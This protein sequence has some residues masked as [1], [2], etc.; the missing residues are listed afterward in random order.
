MA[1]EEFKFLEKAIELEKREELSSVYKVRSYSEKLKLMES[2]EIPQKPI[3]DVLNHLFTEN[4]EISTKTKN[5][6]S[7]IIYSPNDRII[8]LN[9]PLGQDIIWKRNKLIYSYGW[10]F[11]VSKPKSKP[12]KQK[13]EKRKNEPKKEEI[14]IS[15]EILHLGDLSIP[16]KEKENM[17]SLYH[18]RE[19]I[20]YLKIIKSDK[21]PQKPIKEVLHDFLLQNQDIPMKEKKSI[22]KI[23]Y[24]QKERV[25]VVKSL[26]GDKMYE[27]LKRMVKKYGWYFYITGVPVGESDISKAIDKIERKFDIEYFKDLSLSDGNKDGKLR[28]TIYPIVLKPNHNCH[29]LGLG[30]LNI[31][32]DC[33]ISEPEIIQNEAVNEQLESSE[34][35]D[36][37]EIEKDVI[38]EEVAEQEKILTKPDDFKHIDDYLQNFPQLISEAEKE[39]SDI[40]EIE[41]LPPY[42]PKIDAVF[43]SHSHFDHVSGLKKLIKLNPELPILC[44]RITLDLYLL[45]DSNYL[46]QEHNDI[47][48]EEEYRK[49][50]ENVI[51]VENGDK[52]EFK[53]K[54]CFLSFFHAGHMPGALMF[55]A[56]VN[57]FKFLYT[58]DYTYYDITPF[59]GTKRF[60]EQISRPIDYLLIDGT[61]AQEEYGNIA[62]QF[63]SL[64]LF[65]EQK[66]EYEDN[67]LIGA[68]PSS[69][70]I[71]FMLT[72]WRYFRKLQLRK[73]YTKRPNI[74]VDMMVRK[75]IQ[76]INHRYEYIYGPISRLIR[77]KANPFNSIK[78][79][80]FDRK[81]LEFLRNKNNIIISHPPDLSYGLIRNIINVV[82]RNP[83][84]LVFL[85]GAIHEQ[86]GMDLISG[87]TEIEFS[88]TWKAPFRAFL[89]NTFM[90]QL[91][92]KLHADKAQLAEM[93]KILEPREVCFFHQ[94]IK[95]L[96]EVVDYVK[97]L[98]VEKVSLPKK[99][100]LLILN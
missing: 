80:W 16:L 59:A 92:I 77:D 39:E 21:I 19:Y 88:E 9:T 70:A 48:E 11:Y 12:S 51:Y 2:K 53:E 10:F 50:I 15:K 46:K 72:F 68:D 96:I 79:R 14:T 34:Q 42:L 43:I 73:G 71:S 45:R 5:S 28:V 58:G 13:R 56:K 93:I 63:H 3:R 60:L 41:P 85:A 40:D 7:K 22:G 69:L 38:N 61:A 31:L 86:P 44:S 62:D 91:K 67:V 55:L 100:K 54:G 36:E 24:Y 49:I 94:S 57:D 23:I 90:P 81:D 32:L 27:N 37:L 76:V 4:K 98:G 8:I 66:A 95:K 78:F 1:I 97:E 35:L 26:I 52:L 47:I 65:L 6:I 17:R 18:S 99:R 33:G 75:N 20:K 84:N 83:H 74:Y 64:I 82:G 89:I 25:I 30:K 29:I 87:G